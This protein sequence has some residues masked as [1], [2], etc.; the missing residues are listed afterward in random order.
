MFSDL[1]SKPFLG[2]PSGRT[3]VDSEQYQHRCVKPK[4]SLLS[5]A[6][7]LLLTSLFW[8]LVMFFTFPTPEDEPLTRA[9]I[10]T[11]PSYNVTSNRR[12][13]TCG[14]S[15]D[16]AVKMGCKYDASLG[17]WL[18]APCFDQY[19]VNDYLTDGSGTAFADKDLSQR[20]THSEV[21]ER[22]FY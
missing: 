15:T 8:L 13:L 5:H 22:G 9:L 1:E 11:S 6:S 21:L 12:K 2:H 18:A 16:E 20:M 4:G 3:G 17:G 14:N 19:W 7:V 10:S